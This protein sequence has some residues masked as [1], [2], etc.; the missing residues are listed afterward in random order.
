MR[1]CRQLH[2]CAQSG[3]PLGCH[4]PTASKPPAARDLLRGR[5]SLR[6]HP[7]APV[8]RPQLAAPRSPA[9][10]RSFARLQRH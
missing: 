4:H 7:L 5:C 6:Y 8:R 3:C 9:Q 10:R 2:R 1:L